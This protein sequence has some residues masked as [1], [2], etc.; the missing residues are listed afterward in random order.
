MRTG[1]PRTPIGTHGAIT[2]RRN[3]DRT[4][5]ETRVRDLDGRLRQVRVSAPTAAAARARLKERILERPAIPSNGVLQPTSSFADLADLWL[6]DLGEDEPADDRD[7][8]DPESPG[9]DT[10]SPRRRD[11]RRAHTLQPRL[12]AAL[13][14]LK[15]PDV[16][17][18]A[19]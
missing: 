3:G 12:E 16:Y 4:V 9:D 6:A 2:T 14:T 10:P 5:A 18:G 7:E 13:F 8:P 17:Y 19:S 15:A 1:R 11:G